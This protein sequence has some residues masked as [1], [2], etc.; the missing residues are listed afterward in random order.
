MLDHGVMREFLSWL[1]GWSQDTGCTVL[2]GYDAY[3]IDYWENRQLWEEDRSAFTR[4]STVLQVG[5]GWPEAPEDLPIPKSQPYLMVDW[6]L[7]G[8]PVNATH[9]GI[10]VNGDDDN[11]II[12]TYGCAW[13]LEKH[14][15]NRNRNRVYLLDTKWTRPSRAND[16]AALRAV[17]SESADD[18]EPADLAA[19]PP[20]GTTERSKSTDDPEH[21][22]SVEHGLR[23]VVG[24]GFWA[25]IK[26]HLFG[27]PGIH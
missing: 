27:R 14:G 26:R 12:S 8:L 23:S 3:D 1:R 5:Y 9:Y 6:S 15:K 21:I 17:G 20:G 11:A 4:A 24:P 16:A 22:S 7:C 25:W 2:V 18:P 19:A 10:E 13:L